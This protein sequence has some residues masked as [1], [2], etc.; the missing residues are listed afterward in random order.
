MKRILTVFV[1]ALMAVTMVNAK[2]YKVSLG[3]VGGSGIGVQ[4]KALPTEHFA[5][6][7]E[8]GYLGCYA[9]AGKN[10]S[11]GY[12]GAVD[13]LVL[14]YQTSALAEGNGIKLHVYAGGQV[15]VGYVNMGAD[16]GVIGVG[17]AAGLEA[18]MTN[19]PIAFSFDFRPGYGCLLWDNGGGNLGTFNAFDWSLNLGVRY[20]F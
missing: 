14:A 4:F 7:E 11:I 17:A 1:A 6:M 8:F 16:A 20:T 2:D 10:A 18:N 13:Q 15:K 3:A 19:A 12:M 5:I 9:A